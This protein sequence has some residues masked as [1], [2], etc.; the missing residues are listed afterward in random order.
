MVLEV[1]TALVDELG[2]QTGDRPV[3]LD[4]ALDRDLGLG[5]LERVELL[6]RL[7]Q[8]FGVR[9]SD[10]VMAGAISPRDLVTAIRAAG[11]AAVQAAPVPRSPLGEATPAPAGARSCR[12]GRCLSV[13][14]AGRL[15]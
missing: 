14:A 12:P 6:L 2:G 7:E 13:R 8:R 15:R 3:E 11:P 10:A 1:V 9:L 4:D 5:S